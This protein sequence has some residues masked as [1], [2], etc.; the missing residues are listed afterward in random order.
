MNDLS[1]K[2]VSSYLL[3]ELMIFNNTS[4]QLEVGLLK[5]AFEL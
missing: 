5:L 4:Y 1:S 3:D 2:K